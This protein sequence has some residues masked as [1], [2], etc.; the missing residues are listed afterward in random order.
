MIQWQGRQVLRLVSLS[1]RIHNKIGFISTM[2]PRAEV[3][4]PANEGPGVGMD[5]QA[6]VE[7]N[8][9]AAAFLME[10]MLNS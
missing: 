1:K 2:G 5:Q 8:M 3:N 7:R 9:K 10:A 6:T 4:L